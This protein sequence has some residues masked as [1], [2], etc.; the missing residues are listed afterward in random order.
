M[1]CSEARTWLLS[2]EPAALQ[3]DGAGP[4][5]EHLRSC[6]VCRAAADRILEGMREIDA[7]LQTPSHS[8]PLSYQAASRKRMGNRRHVYSA[9]AAAASLVLALVF[10]ERSGRDAEPRGSAA[11]SGTRAS[12]AADP[13]ANFDMR[14][15]DAPVVNVPAGH[16][17]VVFRTSNPRIT[18]V[19]HY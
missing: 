1:N 6:E 14:M 7:L 16:N 3:T 13:A 17:A 19:W 10:V 5:A 11:S 8:L 18:V 9:L 2:A 4:L 12:I 15:L